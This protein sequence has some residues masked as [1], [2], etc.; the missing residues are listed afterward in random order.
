MGQNDPAFDNLMADSLTLPNGR[1]AVRAL[2]LIGGYLVAYVALDWLSY[3]YPIAPLG[4]TPWNPPPGLSLALLLRYGV[5]K[6]PWVIVA[7]FA[8]EIIVRGAPAPLPWLALSSALIGGG[9]TLL[10]WLLLGPLR[11]GTDF[12][13]LRDAALFTSV[14][15]V[16][17]AVLAVAYVGT[18]D[19]AGL[20]PAG[21]FMKS[22]AQFWIGDL[23]G[24]IATTPLLLILIR[25]ES[26]WAGL[27][28]WEAFA[29]V[30]SIALTLWIVFASGISHELNL[31]YLLF[32]PLIWVAMRHGLPG[33]AVAILLI[34]L[35]LI[36][37]LQLTGIA[38]PTVL[39]FQFLLLALAVTGIF[40]G[41]AISERRQAE[42]RLREQQFELDRS[43]RL[44]AASE[45]ASAL[46]HELNQPL[47][48]ISSYVRACQLMTN[49]DASLKDE[50]GETMD[51]V[52]QEAARASG[53]VRRL[54]EFFRA[55]SM[56]L[57]PLEIEPLLRTALAAEQQRTGRHRVSC[58]VDCAAGLPPLLADRVQVE[59]VL[60]NL[61]ANAIDALKENTTAERAIR[62]TAQPEGE[63]LVRVA[64][65]DS[66]PGITHEI[67][68][69]LLH[70]F[71]TSK[72]KGMGLG[73]AIS[74]SIVEAHGGRLSIEAGRQG[75]V[76]FT[77]P[78]AS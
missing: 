74:R 72:P 5:R 44:A 55:G 67:A 70:P 76:S 58:Y 14:V 39:Q 73:L 27:R 4:I 65:A 64:I 56:Q 68:E 57:E 15:T 59:I 41:A 7:A 36:A 37:A 61:L 43:L 1:I 16:A 23:I 20:L 62:L 47:S 42:M 77:L 49:R 50:L 32:L 71:L 33:T 2:P 48:A 11:L 9:Y 8:A 30:A 45:L 29:Q 22:M 28:P 26:P 40:L 51:K 3:I 6:G 53:V 60:H 35:G 10:A 12:R 34:Q 19:L 69:Q 63:R 13:S 78:L 52:V 21:L 66:G 38:A 46:A 25:R 75:L 31:F 17:T 54:R 24:I 18:F